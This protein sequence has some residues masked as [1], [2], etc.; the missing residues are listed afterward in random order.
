[1]KIPFHC[2]LFRLS[3][4]CGHRCCNNTDTLRKGRTTSESLGSYSDLA[5]TCKIHK[6][7]RAVKEEPE[8]K[9]CCGVTAVLQVSAD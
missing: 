1:M 2:R 5:R 7:A 6:L 9:R 8:V 3:S 4:I